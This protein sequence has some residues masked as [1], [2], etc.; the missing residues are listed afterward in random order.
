MCLWTLWI[1]NGQTYTGELNFDKLIKS[2]IAP[3]R[4]SPEKMSK[5]E[6]IELEKFLKSKEKCKFVTIFTFLKLL[7]TSD[8]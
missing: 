2:N 8:G 6:R 1:A 4:Y 3:T 5:N 7:G